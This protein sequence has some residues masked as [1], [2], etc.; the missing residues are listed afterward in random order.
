MID[1]FIEAKRFH[2]ETLISSLSFRIVEAGR[3]WSATVDLKL[4]EA[5]WLVGV[6]NNLGEEGYRVGKWFK[7]KFG[8]RSLLAS[9]KANKA[10]TFLDVGAFSNRGRAKTIVIPAGVNGSGWEA[11]KVALAST[12]A[13][14]KFRN[15]A[16]PGRSLPDRLVD[17]HSFAAVVAGD[18]SGGESSEFIESRRP[19][20]QFWVLLWGLETNHWDFHIVQLLKSSM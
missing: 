4:C 9:C 18:K 16:I 17:G 13:G 8:G 6:L 15:T 7:Q 10:G 3:K 12:T 14:P 5:V 20:E 11:F 2:F 19:V 1:I